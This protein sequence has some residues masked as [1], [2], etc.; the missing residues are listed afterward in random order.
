MILIQLDADPDSPCGL[1][2]QLGAKQQVSEQED[3]TEF[4]GTFNQLHHETIPQQLT[5][6]PTGH[7][8]TMSS[9]VRELRYFQLLR[10]QMQIDAI[11]GS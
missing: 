10:H 3:V 7:N 11:P 8:K 5:V 6:L 9:T 1:F 4:P 2:L